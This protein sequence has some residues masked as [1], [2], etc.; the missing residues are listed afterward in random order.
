MQTGWFADENVFDMQIERYRPHRSARRFDAGTPPV[1]NIYAGVAGSGADRGDRACPRSRR[2]S[3]VSSSGSSPGST[4]SARSAASPPRGPLVCVRSTDAPALVAALAAGRRSSPRNAT[5]AS[6]SRSTSTTPTRTSTPCSPRWRGTAVLIAS[7]QA[8]SRREEVRLVAV[9]KGEPTMSR[10]LSRTNDAGRARRDRSVL[11]RSARRDRLHRFMCDRGRRLLGVRRSRSM[12]A[13]AAGCRGP[14]ARRAG[15]WAPERGRAAGRLAGRAP[16]GVGPCRARSTG[17]GKRSALDEPP[18]RW[19]AGRRGRAS[20]R[21]GARSRASGRS[22]RPRSRSRRAKSC[23]GTRRK[24][25]RRDLAG[26]RRRARR[27]AE[28]AGGRTAS[29]GPATSE[30]LELSEQ[31]LAIFRTLG[32]RRGKALTLN[33]LGLTQ[34]RA[35]RRDRCARLLRDGGGTPDRARAT[36]T[37]PAACSR[38][39]ARSTGGRDRTTGAGS[40]ERRPRAPRAGLARARADGAAAASSAS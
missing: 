31:A 4:R 23:R 8:L 36:T 19:Q 30:A 33:G 40:L 25:V 26:A 9:R 6:A 17:A 10:E 27:A 21:A 24:A 34:A 3:A 39:S 37:A 1:P 16:G 29:G 28:R 11:G 14:R 38:I 7:L 22:G 18:S 20:A 2:T 35:R 5:P 12:V 15:V 32:D 13:A